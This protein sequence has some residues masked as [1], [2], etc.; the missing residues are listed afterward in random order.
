MQEREWAG[1]TPGKPENKLGIRVRCCGEG[2][3]GN[4]INTQCLPWWLLAYSAALTITL[5]F[6]PW[7]QASNTTTIQFEDVKIPV[8]NVLGE[9]CVV[10]T[11]SLLHLR[12]G[13]KASPPPPTP[14]P[15]HHM[16]RSVVASSARSRS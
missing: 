13:W 1:I 2:A 4:P 12:M 3:F 8:E 16:R 5:S 15:H 9:V 14:P 7:R 6:C 11:R 10:G